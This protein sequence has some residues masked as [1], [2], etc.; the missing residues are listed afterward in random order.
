M[1]RPT[2][3]KGA[4]KKL[5]S[6]SELARETGLNRA[7]VR[8]HLEKK[9]VKPREEKPRQKL[10]DADEA[11]RA[12]QED[13]RSGLRKAQTAKT[14]AEAARAEMKLDRERGELVPIQDVRADVQ[15]IWQRIYQHFTVT[16]PATLS[17]QLRGQKVAQVEALLRRDAEHFFSEL[18]AE[19][20]RYLAE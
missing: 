12:L 8:E 16:A 15:T 2:S 6:T 5:L 1:T 14:A 20:E 17:P 9:Q 18:R 19:Q 11:L 4:A 7:T 10:Y 13:D 3:K